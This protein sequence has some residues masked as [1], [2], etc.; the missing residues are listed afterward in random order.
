MY[1]N[2]LYS[3]DDVDWEY[4][5]FCGDARYKTT[6]GRDPCYKK[7]LYAVLSY[8]PLTPCLQRLYSWKATSKHMTWHA[9]H[10]MWEGSMCHPSNA[11]AWKHF[12]RMYPDFA[13]ESHNIR[14]GL[15]SDGFAL[16]GQCGCTSSCCPIIIT[17]YNI[18]PSMCMS[19]EYMFLTMVIPGPSNPERLIDVYLRPLIQELL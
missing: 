5:K 2:M 6:R 16:H 12:D 9:T 10:Q 8:L 18:L 17:P 4:C 3:K 7:S 1:D 13:E 14:L 19:S 15:C 11:K